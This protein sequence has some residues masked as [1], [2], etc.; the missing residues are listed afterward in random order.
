[1]ENCNFEIFEF[2]SI[3]KLGMQPDKLGLI[4]VFEKY[5]GIFNP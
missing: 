1:M 2:F 4:C 5:Y 3:L